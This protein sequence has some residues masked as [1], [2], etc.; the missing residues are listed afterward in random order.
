MRALEP[1][2]LCA[3][4]DP[5]GLGALQL[6]RGTVCH[7]SHAGENRPPPTCSECTRLPLQLG[8]RPARAASLS[9]VF[10]GAELVK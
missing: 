10:G 8:C 9:E 1:R 6:W 2:N 7:T 4:Q 3:L 5:C